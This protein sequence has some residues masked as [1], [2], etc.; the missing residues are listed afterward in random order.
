VNL[1]LIF[2]FLGV[3]CGAHPLCFALGKENSPNQFSGTAVAVTNTLIML[4]GLIFQPVVGK[5]LDKHAVNVMLQ[6]GVPIYS[7]QDYTY[8][9]S[10]IPIG[11]MISIFLSFMLKETYCESRAPDQRQSA[12]SKL[13]FE[14]K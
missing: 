9:L 8:A 5:L 13:V 3:F 12:G 2:F 10:I 4:G 6:D 11:L 7:A 1:Y 14:G